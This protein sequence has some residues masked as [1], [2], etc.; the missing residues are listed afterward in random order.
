MR[1]LDLDDV[2]ARPLGMR[3]DDVGAGGLVAGATT[4]QDGSLRQAGGPD[5]SLNAAAAMGR[6]V[7]PSARWSARAGRLRKP[8]GPAQG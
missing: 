1:A 2:G 8:P 4:A 5:T 7:A 6:W 3:P